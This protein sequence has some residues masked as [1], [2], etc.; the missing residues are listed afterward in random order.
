SLRDPDKECDTYPLLKIPG[1]DVR[2]SSSREAPAVLTTCW[3]C[4]LP[5]FATLSPFPILG[6]SALALR[7]GKPS[8]LHASRVH[9][10]ILCRH[11]P[12]SIFHRPFS[13]PRSG[14]SHCFSYDHSVS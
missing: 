4:P 5:R 14:R 2:A 9:V 11:R 10:A 12:N 8:L 13:F 3:V 1:E 7:V 6:L